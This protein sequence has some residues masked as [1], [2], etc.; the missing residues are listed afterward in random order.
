[1]K[2]RLMLFSAIIIA[3]FSWQT[4]ELL[5]QESTLLTLINGTLIDGTGTDSVPDAVAVIQ[6]E[7]ITVI[8][9]QVNTAI[10]VNAKVI[11]VAG[12]TILPG[13]INA[14]VHRGYEEQNLKAWAQAGVTAVRDLATNPQMPAF[15][16]R[17]R[18]NKSNQN[19]RLVA[20][21]PMVTT[22]GG[23]YGGGLEVTSSEDARQ[24]VNEL[25]D[26]GA[27]LIKIAIEDNLQGRKWPMLSMEE[28]TT[29]VNTAHERGL[30][31]SA[32][33]TRSK[34]LEIAIE[35]K[36]DDVAHMVIDDLP[37]DLITRMIE[38]D[39]YWEPTLELW[40]GVSQIH[41]LN[42]DARAVA[43]L[44]RFVQAG[45]KVA[46]G[47][48]YAGYICEFDLGMPITEMELMQEAGMTPMQIIVAGTKN[49]A[50]V[51]NLD[52]ELGTIEPGKIADVIVV[53]GNPLHDIHALTNLRI[54]I[55]KGDVIRENK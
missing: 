20:V 37:D 4:S 14:H 11:D 45:G 8:G 40:K 9:T 7:R 51:C 27:D 34:H 24:K 38:Q 10:P 50:H 44:H 26:A 47:T 17:D 53:E 42:W 29:I 15:S 30:P 12:S 31:V 18:L 28:I 1:M 46:L 22:I 5:C 25:A 43:N 52:H 35:A 21:G 3:M 23:Y 49:A 33:I 16:I 39:M 54:V 41:N 32:H 19:A 55:H 36:V 6:N 2:N 13:L 48:D